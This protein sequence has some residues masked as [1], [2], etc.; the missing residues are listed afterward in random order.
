MFGY[1]CPKNERLLEPRDTKIDLGLVCCHGCGE[2]LRIVESTIELMKQGCKRSVPEE[3][4]SAEGQLVKDFRKVEAELPGC[5]MKSLYAEWH[6]LVQ[7]G[8]P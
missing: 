3:V 2:D 7:G 1:L 8:M 6:C 4:Q 5:L